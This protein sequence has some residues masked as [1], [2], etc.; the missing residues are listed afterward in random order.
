MA[1]I[2]EQ[3]KKLIQHPADNP[4][5]HSQVAKLRRQIAARDKMAARNNRR[6]T[7]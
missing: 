2:D 4:N 6:N 1:T 5:W 3:L 7:K